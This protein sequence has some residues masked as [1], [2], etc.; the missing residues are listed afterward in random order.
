M[1]K[2]PI[3]FVVRKAIFKSV[4]LNRLLMYVFSLPVYVKVAHFFL[5][6][7]G[8][9]VGVSLLVGGLWVLIG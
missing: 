5:T 4:F 1:S 8:G 3:A 6:V 9:L 7:R 2:L